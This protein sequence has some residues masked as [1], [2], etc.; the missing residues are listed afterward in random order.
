MVPAS[1]DL[2]EPAGGAS[3]GRYGV[4]ATVAYLGSAFAGFAPQ[5]GQRTVA[6]EILDALRKL[7]PSI[8][9]V[10]GVSRTDAGV[11]A[12]GQR[13]AFDASVPIPPRG[14]VLGTLRHLP[15]E[16]AFVK[17]AKIRPNFIPR[18]H[19]L[20]KHYRYSILDSLQRDPFLDGRVMRVETMSRPDVLERAQR[21]AALALGTHDFAAFRSA[22]DERTMTVRSL[23][24]LDVAPLPSDPRVICVDV[25]GD[26]FMHNMVRILVGTLV[27]VGRGRL[28]PGAMTRAFASLDRRDA[29]FTAPPD[30]LCLERVDLDDEGIDAW[31]L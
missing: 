14:W 11:H 16:I 23:R 2:S 3:G 13:I 21:E 10:R 27:D 18:F 5:P 31:P 6:G 4:L 7:D 22:A 9:E 30:G 15:R 24:R 20:Q 8:D 28:A 25:E 26:A 1:S 17:A 12:K 29:G 19:S